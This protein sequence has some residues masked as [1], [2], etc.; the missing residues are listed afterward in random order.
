M[1][2]AALAVVSPFVDRRH[3]TE[4]CLAEQIERLVL[5]HGWVVHLYSQRVEGLRAPVVWHRIPALPGPHLLK[6][7]WWFVA[8]HLWRWWDRR[9]R[10]L[11]TDL[12]YS[13][14]INCFDARVITVHIVFA[15]FCR[16]IRDE[17]RLL[18]N[19]FRMWPRLVHRRLYYRLIVVL[20]RLIYKRGNMRLNAI[21]K[22]TA[23]D[24]AR[25]YGR[26]GDV[27]VGYHGIDAVQFNPEA[28]WRLRAGAR[29]NLG[30]TS[31]NFALLLIGNDWKK[32]GL[33]CLLEAAARLGDPAVRILVVGE[34]DPAL[35]R[36]PIA[37]L[38]LD[39]RVL[40]LPTRPDV[41]AYYAAADCYVGA[42]LED[43]FALPPLE[44][45]ACGLPVIVSAE[46]GVSEIVTDGAD[47]LVL[48]DP[49]DPD[50]LAFLLRRVHEDTGLRRALG[51]A[52]ARTARH[53]TWDRNASELNA[54]LESAL[55]EKVAR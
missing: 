36:K 10:G 20:E 31:K 37:R 18:R 39:G 48:K 8:N 26:N 33:G 53:Y 44:A 29:A 47:A 55:R 25:L 43:A 45:M 23:M 5:E 12:T 13:P 2:K 28:R 49:R 51:E 41:E 19:P 11:H 34:D 14:G 17:L 35:F 6:Y 42:S 30:L 27:A 16:E 46:A 9:V 50:A 22:K 15:Q 54:V 24:L 7:L 3:G 4:R 38:E 40:C 52:A 21:S 1:M 32:K